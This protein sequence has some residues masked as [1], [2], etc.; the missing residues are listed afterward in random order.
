MSTPEF[1]TFFLPGPTEVRR[2]VLE[3]MTRPMISHRGPEF[4]EIFD[5]AQDGMQT[6]FGTSRPV[7]IGTCSATGFMEAGVRAA[8]E[9]RVLSLVNG[10][11]SERFAHVA[12]SCGRRVERYVVEWGDAHQLQE[13]SRRLE[14]AHFA[15]VTVAH[16]ETSSGVLNDIHAISDMVHNY[17]AVCLVDSVSGTAGAELRADAWKLDYVL[18]GSQKALALP[19]GLAFAV[20]SSAFIDS[21]QHQERAAVRSGTYFDITEFEEAALKHQVPNTPS[22]SL[23]YALDVQLRAIAAE[24]MEARWARHLGMQAQT[25]RWISETASSLGL[26][27]QPLASEGHRSPTVTAVALPDDIPASVVIRGAA[28]RGITVGAGYGKLRDSTIRI[29]HMGD[30][31]PAT[32]SR[33]LDACGAALAGASA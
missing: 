31:T 26:Q 3:A 12:E 2:E 10:A 13:L 17:G 25:I 1:G 8:P 21:A 6:V 18:T 5:R 32:I 4:E 14:S 20:A 23:Y 19:P 7:Y 11:F 22:I 15:V 16:S 24:G 28:E 30:H 29:G 33:C 9:G 27:I